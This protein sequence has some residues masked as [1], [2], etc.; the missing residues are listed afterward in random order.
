MISVVLLAA[1]LLIAM[2]VL[3]F[4]VAIYALP[5]MI[6]LAASRLMLGGGAGWAIAVAGGFVVGASSFVILVYMQAILRRPTARIAVALVYATP[7]AFAGYAVMYGLVHDLSI[8]DFLKQSLC[9]ASGGF[10]AVLAVLRL[11]IPR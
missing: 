1:A 5:F 11:T 7:A 10:V 2:C 6:G 4:T 3:A 9:L 8:G